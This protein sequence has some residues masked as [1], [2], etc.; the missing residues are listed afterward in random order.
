MAKRLSTPRHYP[1]SHRYSPPSTTNH[2]TPPFI[3]TNTK[4]YLDGNPHKTRTDVDICTPVQQDT[5]PT[6]ATLEAEEQLLHAQL[7]A[8][9]N[10]LSTL[11]AHT[12]GTTNDT[13]NPT[14]NGIAWR[15]LK[16]VHAVISNTT[17]S[18]SLSSS[19]SP[20]PLRSRSPSHSTTPSPSP[21]RT[22]LPSYSN[23]LTISPSISRS[24]R[25]EYRDNPIDRAS[26]LT[27]WRATGGPQGHWAYNYSPHS[28]WGLP[29][30]S[31]CSWSGIGCSLL[32]YENE[33]DNDQKYEQRVNSINVYR[34]NLTGTLPA[35]M[36]RMLYVRYLLLG[37]NM[38]LVG[39]VPSCL[40][41]DMIFVY[42]LSLEHT[43]LTGA[44][45]PIVNL[46]NLNFLTMSS[47]MYGT[48]PNGFPMGMERL[49]A[50]RGLQM[51]R[52]GLHGVM[53][54][55]HALCQLLSLEVIDLANNALQGPLPM[56][57]SVF[58]N[59]TD[60]DIGSNPINTT[61]PKC[62][63]NLP[64]I[65]TISLPSTQLSGPLPV[66]LPRS[67]TT[68]YL[69]SN[70]LTGTIPDWS[71]LTQLDYLQLDGNKLTGP[72]PST[73]CTNIKL[74]GIS[75]NENAL[76]GDFPACLLELGLRYT[77]QFVSFEHNQLSGTLKPISCP[78]TNST[79]NMDDDE[80]VNCTETELRM[81]MLSH[82]RF[83]GS[84]PHSYIN[85]RSMWKLVLNNNQLSGPLPD[86]VFKN[87]A[88]TEVYLHSNKLSGPLSPEFFRIPSLR[89][90]SLDHNQ[91]TGTVPVDIYGNHSI[92]ALSASHNNLTGPLPYSTNRTRLT[93]L[94]SLDLS[95]NNLTDT[96]MNYYY[97]NRGAAYYSFAGNWQMQA[98]ASEVGNNWGPMPSGEQNFYNGYVCPRLEM[99]DTHALFEVSPIYYNFTL[100]SCVPGYFGN[101]TQNCTKCPQNGLCAGP[102]MTWPRGFYPVFQNQV[103]LGFLPCSDPSTL[104][105]SDCNAFNNC[106][107]AWYQAGKPNCRLCAPGSEDRLCSRCICES[108][109]DCYYRRHNQCSR[110][111]APEVTYSI[112]G[113][114]VLS[115]V[116]IVLAVMA[117]RI[118]LP[119]AF[120]HLKQAFECI[121]ESGTLKVLLIY[122]QTTIALNGVWPTWVA[123]HGI[124]VLELA[125][126]QVIAL[127][128]PC[129]IPAL[130]KP[131]WEQL[132]YLMIIPVATVGLA[133]VVGFVYG[134]RRLLP[135]ILP[136]PSKYAQVGIVN[137]YK[138]VST[139]SI[140]T[141]IIEGEAD[142]EEAIEG[143]AESDEGDGDGT[144]AVV[145][146]HWLLT[147]RWGVSVWMFFVY[148]F[149]FNLANRA[150]R[151]FNCV[152]DPLLNGSRYMQTLP[153][154]QCYTA[155]G[156]W[157]KMAS[158]AVVMLVVYIAGIPVLFG[159]LL[160]RYRKRTQL[161]HVR[162]MLHI[163]YYSYRPQRYWFELF[164]IARRLTLAVL[165]SVVERDSI[166]R[167]AAL[168]TVLLLCI[169]VQCWIWPFT[170]RRDNILEVVALGVI[171]LTFVGQTSWWNATKLVNPTVGL[172]AQV[173]PVTEGGSSLDGDNVLLVVMALANGGLLAVMTMVV[174]WPLVLWFLRLCFPKSVDR[175]ELF[176]H[177]V[178]PPWL[179]TLFN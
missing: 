64:K 51:R 99:I 56:C 72:I 125:N 14:D 95:Y 108:P 5:T 60:F 94:V 69:T 129:I 155:T 35:E 170:R 138:V 43:M 123:Q 168:T 126:G 78:S 118:F 166:Y 41:T 84:I 142:S 19:P 122:L 171:T 121:A 47:P 80:N 83:Y 10:G 18:P 62:I 15:V 34:Y 1:R 74:Q 109:S 131:V 11:I 103:I 8:V 42:Q 179:Y 111:E 140:D 107:L 32:P 66:N 37:L 26:L 17:T 59:L 54:E 91:F 147:W 39:P 33:D 176:I 163:L 144:K 100:C 146:G 88:L 28:P 38:G 50:L 86:R 141:P 87:T 173:L 73:L 20:S 92:V 124:H 177:K 79:I 169:A 45:P 115:I 93:S 104:N 150:L 55:D 68:L 152:A 6:L 96:A 7:A 70:A 49:A 117:L 135:F 76:T 98:T 24:P 106:S 82:N 159:W 153:W 174:V 44:F 143:D 25:P 128:L 119:V 164:I 48:G 46:N 52:S 57:L 16:Q 89:F 105:S 162:G 29:H 149:F 61:F 160:W 158:M 133:F 77:L 53:S 102:N 2:N 137:D 130:G 4:D 120:T 114:V 12:T 134:F 172:L 127:G 27:F 113:A 139:T 85:V 3:T 81:I 9:R 136:K 167:P 58:A 175:A 65:E 178:T 154:V 36:C 71:Y 112:L 31:M 151:V 90:A 40:G 110:C 30:T 13:T 116:L 101:P 75:A 23:S 63:L 165:I 161:P 67:V 132:I 157:P 145:A 21:S 22:P 148:F 156:A 97:S